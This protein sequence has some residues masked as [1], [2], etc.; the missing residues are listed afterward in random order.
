MRIDQLYQF[1][2][3][4]VFLAI[5]AITHVLNK[6]AQALP[7]RTGGRPAGAKPSYEPF[8]KSDDDRRADA[9]RREGRPP[10]PRPRS[11]AIPPEE[12]IVILEQTSSGR[13]GRPASPSTRRTP[14]GR[15]APAAP[16]KKKEVSPRHTFGAPLSSS[17]LTGSTVT[18][19]T[20]LAPLSLEA[21]TTI[22]QTTSVET[23]RIESPRTRPVERKAVSI[24]EIHELLRSPARVGE[25]FILSELLSA[26][27]SMRGR[28]NR[29]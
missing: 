14:R 24:E 12:G 7:P 10:S 6:D 4:L 16:A 23:S 1:L 18:H 21:A 9:S 11:T 15:A 2:V 22:A 29:R 27:V 5:W 20:S 3:P 17:P 13:P 8:T 19:P 25:A 26:P 28:R